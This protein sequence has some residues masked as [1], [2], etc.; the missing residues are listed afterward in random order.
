[1]QH[2][3]EQAHQAIKG[4]RMHHWPVGHRRAD[5]L[6]PFQQVA[7]REEVKV[8]IFRLTLGQGDLFHQ[9]LKRPL[10]RALGRIEDLQDLLHFASLQ[11]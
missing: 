3:P 11:L 5:A 10:C 2:G 1:M 4:Q 7:E 9:L 6:A 8:D